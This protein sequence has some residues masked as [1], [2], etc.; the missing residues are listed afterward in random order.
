M[1]TMNTSDEIVY[2]ARFPSMPGYGAVCADVPEH[3]KNTARTIA[4]WI[5][6]GG[7][8]ERVP[9]QAAIDGM[10]EYL[11]AIQAAKTTAT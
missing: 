6:R 1:S 10:R 11:T 9:R 3:K 8:V 2:A 4:G 5:K 7:T